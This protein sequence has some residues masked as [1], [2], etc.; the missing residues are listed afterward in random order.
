MKYNETQI[1]ANFMVLEDT[2]NEALGAAQDM[3][4]LVY[5]A[6]GDSELFRKLSVYLTPNLQHWLTGKQ[7]GSIVDITECMNRVEKKKK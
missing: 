6:E 2:L 1:G 3:Q 5:E 7:S 4:R